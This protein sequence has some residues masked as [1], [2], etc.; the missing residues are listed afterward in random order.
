MTKWTVLFLTLV[1]LVAAAPPQPTPTPARAPV[2]SPTP[3]AAPPAPSLNQS[4]VILIYPFEV[5]T[6]ADPK[7]GIAI[8][9]ILAQEMAAAGGLEVL[10]IPQGVKRANFLDYAHAQ[11]ADFYISGYVTPVGETAA[12]VEQVVSVDSGVILFSQTA[13]VSS[14]ADVASQSLLAR[15]QILAFTGRGTQNVQPQAS[16]TPAPSSTNGAKVPISG[17]GSI[18]DSVFKHKG[19]SRGAS[20]APTTKPSRGV[21]VAPVTAASAITSTDLASATHELYFAMN[22]FFNAQMTG[23]TSA[24][25][26][27]TD[28]ICGSNRDNTVAAGTLQ[29]ARVHNHTQVTFDLTMYTCFGAPLDH[30]VGKGA[31][32]KAAVDAAVSAYVT[33]HPDNS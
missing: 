23:V 15:T 21:I 16:N 31:S 4:P 12:V 13:Q 18:V 33:A 9:Q 20:P 11:K 26:Q 30:Q 29:A 1:L 6:G 5:Q 32:Y 25:A 22:H 8:G 27:S 7:I 3:S 2:P 28:Q 24:P 14:V 17:I 10:A 19:S